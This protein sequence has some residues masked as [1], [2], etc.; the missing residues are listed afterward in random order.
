M[1]WIHFSS[2]YSDKVPTIMEEEHPTIVLEI[3]LQNRHKFLKVNNTTTLIY[4]CRFCIGIT[5]FSCVHVVL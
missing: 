3:G 4:L 2:S 5:Q 1:V